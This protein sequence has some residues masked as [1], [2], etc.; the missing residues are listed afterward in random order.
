MFGAFISG[1][2]DGRAQGVGGE[3]PQT[4][5][6]VARYPCMVWLLFADVQSHQTLQLSPAIDNSQMRG[7]S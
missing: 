3:F 7:Q 4:S 2:E 1:R 6:A 5:P